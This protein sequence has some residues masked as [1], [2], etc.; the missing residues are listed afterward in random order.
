M[1]ISRHG[2]GNA[3]R[4]PYPPLGQRPARTPR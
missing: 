1:L 4:C 2:L 3:R